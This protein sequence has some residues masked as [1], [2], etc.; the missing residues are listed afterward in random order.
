[1]TV[2]SFLFVGIGLLMWSLSGGGARLESVR[3]PDFSPLAAAGEATFNAYCAE[4]HGANASGTDQG[5][6]LLHNTYN[7]GHHGDESFTIAVSHGVPGHHWSYGNM[8]PQPDVAEHD[9]AAVV[10]YV[11]ELQ[12]ANGIK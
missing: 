5:P 6:P 12:Q 7:P 8:P 10:R 3:V 4:C 9:V 2:V 11:R 1:M